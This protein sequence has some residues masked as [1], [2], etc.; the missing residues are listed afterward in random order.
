MAHRQPINNAGYTLIEI[1][2]AM[3]ISGVV[4][5]GIY[6][7]YTQQM[8]V[9]N[10]QSLVVDMQQNARVAM[11]FMER[12]IRVAGYN[13][14]GEPR[15]GIDIPNR[16]LIT[17]SV[18]MTGG[19]ADGQDNDRDGDIDESPECDGLPDTTITYSLSNDAGNNGECDFITGDNSP[20]NLVRTLGGGAPQLLVSNIDA[21]DFVYMGIDESSTST[22]TGE[23]CPLTYA[24]TATPEGQRNI[25]AVQ[26]TIIARAGAE[27]PG[28]SVP[29]TDRNTY[30][31]LINNIILTP[32]NPANPES[33][34]FR[35]VRLTSEVRTRNIGLL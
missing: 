8:R 34:R 29:Y 25:R 5:G 19:E 20:C 17:L 31:N 27:I 3:A 7:A 10:T 23:N 16:G 4:L 18:D 11:N 2:I 1:L 33:V 12:D 14:L 13:P 9:N 22:C 6:Q 35:R 24:Y 15:I 32:T 30:S 28:L 21:L 26:I